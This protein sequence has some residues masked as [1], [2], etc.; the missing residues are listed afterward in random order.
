MIPWC[1]IWC[2]VY[3]DKDEIFSHKQCLILSDKVSNLG[4][5]QIIFLLV[6]FLFRTHFISRNYISF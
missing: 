6:S 3:G 4:V 5:I 2:K 1:I